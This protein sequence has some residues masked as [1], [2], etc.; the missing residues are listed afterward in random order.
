MNWLPIDP[1]LVP[2]GIPWAGGTLLPFDQAIGW[3]V[4]AALGTF[5]M[6][7]SEGTDIAGSVAGSLGSD[8]S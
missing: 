4:G 2:N 3:V 7:A 8:G 6:S 1:W 5:L